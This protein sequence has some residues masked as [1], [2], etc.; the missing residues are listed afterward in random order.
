[1]ANRNKSRRQTASLAE[2]VLDGLSRSL[3]GQK[4]INGK[5]CQ[6]DWR[7]IEAL[8]AVQAALSA[9][10]G[11]STNDLTALDKAIK[12]ADTLSE[13]VAMVDPPGCEPKDRTT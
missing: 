7:I 11:C 1:M 8:R 9:C 5:L 4:E 13:K 2:D 10:A 12:T 6:V 3:K